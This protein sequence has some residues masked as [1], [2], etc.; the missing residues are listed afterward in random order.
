MGYFPN[1]IAFDHFERHNCAHCIHNNDSPDALN[2]PVIELHLLFNY[3]QHGDKDIKDALNL[4][5]PTESG[6]NK[7]CRMYQEAP[8]QTPWDNPPPERPLGSEVSTA[9]P[10][11]K[12]GSP[13]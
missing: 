13:D 8:N 11:K 2:C 12:G 5:I 6:Q 3:D 7:N 1:S 4:F 10:L 9:V